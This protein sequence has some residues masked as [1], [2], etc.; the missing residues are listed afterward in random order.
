MMHVLAAAKRPWLALL[1]GAQLLGTAVPVAD[2]RLDAGARGPVHIEA[3]TEQSCDPVHLH[4]DCVLCQH[5]SQRHVV[6]PA[7]ATSACA[8]LVAFARPAPPVRRS[9][10]PPAFL[11]RGRSPP[12]VEL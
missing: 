7:T 11:E 4:D 6:A 1:L 12:A 8:E 10:T 3:R 5:L 2:A 9:S